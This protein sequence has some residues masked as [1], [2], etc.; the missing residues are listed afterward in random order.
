MKIKT[1][2]D[3]TIAYNSIKKEA[4]EADKRLRIAVLRSFTCEALEKLLM[5]DVYESGF[6]CEFFYGGYNQYAQE[7]LDTSSA[8]YDFKPD[9]TL[10]LINIEDLNGQ[11]FDASRIAIPVDIDKVR[12]SIVEMTNLISNY[13]ALVKGA[14]IVNNFVKPNFISST[15]HDAMYTY[16]FGNLVQQANHELIKSIQELDSV[17]VLDLEGIVNKMGRDNIYDEKQWYLS[18]NPYN[19]SFY[20]ELSQSLAGLINAIHNRRKKC[21]VLDLDN[22]LWHGVIGEDGLTGI[23]V[24]AGY[25]DFQK[26]LL[27]WKNSGILLAINSKN[28]YEDAIEVFE[29]HPDMVLKKSDFA[30]FAI[31]WNDKAL[32]MRL[33]ADELNIGVDSLVFIDDSVYECEY[34][35][36]ECPDVYVVQLDGNYVSYAEIARNLPLVNFV[37][38]SEEDKT[39]TRLYKEEM[40]R[41]IL[42]SA[43]SNLE[44][45]LESLGTELTIKPV[46][47]ITIARAAQLTQKTNQFN[48]TTRRY[49]ADELEKKR[50]AGYLIYTIGVTDKFGD[51]GI[52]GLVIIDA[53]SEA[54]NVWKIDNFLLSCRVMGRDIEK[55]MWAFVAGKAGENGISIIK[56]EYLPTMKNKPVEN[57]LPSLG[58][59]EVNGCLQYDVSTEYNCPCY[60][61]IKE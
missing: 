18:R 15:Y 48:L 39:R 3:Y 54:K 29:K 59:T 10:F 53:S 41:K 27:L 26:Q 19:T 40:D 17:F 61:G 44:S 13:R 50:E 60:I 43:S 45:Y 51:S 4:K 55:G 21:I 33:I 38:L 56:G 58:F 1:L 6:I 34:V 28:N 7:V 35:K 5:V 42:L 47:Y 23:E 22:T 20:I 49:T 12:E 11:V 31:N 32:N 30:F 14:I 8:L 37:F 2:S 57:L 24:C 36:S 16:G 52:T 9:I 46:D 25:A